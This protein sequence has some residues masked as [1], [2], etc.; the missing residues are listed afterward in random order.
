MRSRLLR[1]TLF[2]VAAMVLFGALIPAE[3]GVDR[4]QR[5]QQA[6]IR[7]G[8]RSGELTRGEARRLERG[9][10][11]IARREARARRDGNFTRRERG[12]IQRQLNRESRAIYRQ[13][14]D[15]QDR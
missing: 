11:R 3:A 6:R 9:E 5:R 12:R 1:A 7:Q 8:V 14:H 2:G 15:R 10:A 13:K 4:R